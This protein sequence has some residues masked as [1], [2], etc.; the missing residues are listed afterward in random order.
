V[1]LAASK[2]AIPWINSLTDGVLTSGTR[3]LDSILDLV[4]S[5]PSYA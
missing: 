5:Y 1:H 4:L 3:L 2:E